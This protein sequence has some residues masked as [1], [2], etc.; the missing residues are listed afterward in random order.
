MRDLKGHRQM[1]GVRLEYK[2]GEVEEYGW[3][4]NMNLN[5][6]ELYTQKGKME[7]PESPVAK[8]ELI[9]GVFLESE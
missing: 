6:G 3:T 4:T 9:R 2:D 1:Y 8:V 5:L 7:H